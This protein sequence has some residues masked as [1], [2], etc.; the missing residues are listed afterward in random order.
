LLFIGRRNGALRIAAVAAAPSFW[1]SILGRERRSRAAG[2]KWHPRHPLGR[3]S[4][5]PRAAV[6]GI[7]WQ[8][9]SK[10][11]GPVSSTPLDWLFMQNSFAFYYNPD[12]YAA[13][14]P[15]YLL[16]LLYA[17]Y[18]RDDASVLLLSTYGGYWLVYLMG[19]HTLYSY[20]A[21]QLSPLAHMVLAPA[22]ASL[23]R[24]AKRGLQPAVRG[25]T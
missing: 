15:L 23:W 25:R 18:K 21:A 9:T 6:T 3:R 7:Q 5:F 20:Y 11:P 13:G 22:L 19:N 2:A 8:L 24:A 17:L 12:I 10:P 14:S 4:L 1:L 16:A